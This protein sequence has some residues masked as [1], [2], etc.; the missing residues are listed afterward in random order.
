MKYKQMAQ[1]QRGVEE[2]LSR[3]TTLAHKHEVQTWLDAKGTD[4]E[5]LR[6]ILEIARDALFA[7]RE[8]KQKEKQARVVKRT[9]GKRHID[10]GGH[11]GN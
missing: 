10:I 5:K 11:D 6:R 8:V 7:L 4:E 1:V 3:I 2:A 9:A